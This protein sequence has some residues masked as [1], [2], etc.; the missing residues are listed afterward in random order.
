MR[1][2]APGD[3]AILSA[4]LAKTPETA[5]FLRSNLAAGGLEDRDQ[6][7]QGTYVGAFDGEDLVGVA[8][9]YWNGNAM[10]HAP[11]ARAAAL[12]AA[13]LAACPG[14]S[15]Q[16][17]LG[18]PDAVAEVLRL[19]AFADRHLRVA[20]RQVLLA[21]DLADL[22]PPTAHTD[23]VRAADPRDRE[24]LADWRHA[25]LREA[26]GAQ[27][28]PALRIQAQDEIDRAVDAGRL[29]LLCMGDNILATAAFNATLPEIV[30][31]GGLYCPPAE[32]GLGYGRIVLHGALLAAREKGVARAVLFAAE[33][34]V[35][36]LRSSQALGFKPA[37]DYALAFY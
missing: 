2:L 20:A 10:L 6:P 5:M 34:N 13:A 36:A 18:A 30:Q 11:T 21:C 9:L 3:E 14:R 25:Y 35:A 8:A 26:L 24:A 32:R 31:V 28:S 27:D 7:Y 15:C 33:A 4:F 16:G 22:P 12:A 19:P 23:R 1:I 37:A 29:Y 17:V